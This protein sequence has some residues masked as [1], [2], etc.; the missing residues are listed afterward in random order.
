M[1]DHSIVRAEE[2]SVGDELP[3]RTFESLEREDFVRY[4]GASGDFNPLHYDEPYAQS[5]GR[6]TVIG[7]GML[8]A[9]YVSSVLSAWAGPEHVESF[10]VR[11]TAA[12]L[13]GEDITVTGEVVDRREQN[14]EVEFDVELT[15]AN[16][17]GEAV[18]TGK[19]TAV[20]PSTAVTD[21]R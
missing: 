20:V 10:T 18:V 4:A 3:S 19:G 11:F 15:A 6:D 8:V 17:D 12:I 16:G 13:P 1:S 7:Q 2:V 14:D 9:G 5:A 21:E